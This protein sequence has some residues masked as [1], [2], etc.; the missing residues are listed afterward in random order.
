MLGGFAS[1]FAIVFAAGAVQGGFPLPMKYT[2]IW[3]WENIWLAY[4][5]FGL[6]IFPWAVA[7]WTIPDLGGVIRTAPASALIAPFLF[8]AA[9]GV[10][11]LLFGLGVHRVGLSLTLG[12]VIGLTSALGSL[13]PM[14]FLRPE[15]LVDTGAFVAGSVVMTF[16]GLWFCTAAGLQRER[17]ISKTGFRRGTFWAGVAICVASG[18][19]SPLFNFA[20]IFGDPVVRAAATRGATEFN[21]PNLI[22]AIA[23]TGGLIPTAVYCGYLLWRNRTWTRFGLPGQGFET[24]LAILMG[25]MFAFSNSAYGMGASKLGKLGPIVGWPVFM[26]I[27]VVAGNIIG[28]FTGEWTGVP[29]RI[30]WFLGWG[31]I[32]LIAAAFLVAPAGS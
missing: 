17:S 22:L 8:G 18:V 23:M 26:A 20:L 5:V 6:V 3:E 4:S 25:A 28:L 19:L 32:A 21:A 15:H 10:G 16:I 11:G 14:L 13:V 30:L 12:I 7:A 1:G 24:G 31:S 27:Q 2:R 29:R 9:W